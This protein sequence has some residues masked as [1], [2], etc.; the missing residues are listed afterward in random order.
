MR[1]SATGRGIGNMVD[2]LPGTG[3]RTLL[4][5]LAL[6]VGITFFMQPDSDAT[7][8]GSFDDAR[9]E[10]PVHQQEVEAETTEDERAEKPPLE[11]Q[12][13]EV[14]VEGAPPPVVR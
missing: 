3:P 2:S 5:A 8:K 7:A 12:D 4:G 10:N 9:P 6:V 14:Q 13:L 1:P 11:E